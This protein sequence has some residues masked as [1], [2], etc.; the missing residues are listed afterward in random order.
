VIRHKKGGGGFRD[1]HIGRDVAMFSRVQRKGH[2]A[3]S[4]QKEEQILDNCTEVMCAGEIY[5][6]K[7]K[8]LQRPTVCFM[9]QSTMNSILLTG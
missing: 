5:Y 9:L 2:F 3:E 4:L 1:C 7:D 6:T 8:S